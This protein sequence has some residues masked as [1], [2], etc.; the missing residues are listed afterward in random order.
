MPYLPDERVAYIVIHYSATPIEREYPY[1]QLERDHKQRGFRE[2][3]YHFYYPRKGGEIAGRDLSSPGR[4]E[5]GA[6]SQ[7]ENEIS[8]GL[9]FE[10]GVTLA[11]R[12]NGF[13]SRTDGQK[14]LMIARIDA[15]KERFPKAVVKGHRDMP[16][17]ATQCPGH[18]AAA[19]W[20]G[21]VKARNTPPKYE[22]A[23]PNAWTAFWNALFGGWKK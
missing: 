7:G 4:F 10:G 13:D 9:C 18:D 12:N 2:G 17:A 19:W 5:V 16:G 3:G 23:A 20:D 21:V 8:I 6:H 15:L 14:A 11:D 22:P 1:A